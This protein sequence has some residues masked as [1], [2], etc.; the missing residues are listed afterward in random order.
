MEVKDL[1]PALIWQCFD[2]ITKVPRPSTHEEQIRK[3]LL[4]FAA[5][6]NLEARTDK[7]GNVAM[8]KGA[9]PGYE[10]APTVILQAHMDMVAEKNND[11]QHDFL[12]DPIET[13]IDGDWVRAR[14]TTL[15]ADNGIGMAAGLAVML[16]NTWSTAPSSASSPSTRKSASKAHRTSART[17]SRAPSS[18]TST[19][20]TTARSS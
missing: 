20:K 10:N 8:S 2:A 6:H 17:S 15:G 16:D 18:S 19:P 9:T 1:K 4:D 7:V 12:K 14:G 11:V 5:E 3:F 13:Y